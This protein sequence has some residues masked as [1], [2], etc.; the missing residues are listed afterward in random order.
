MV[1]TSIPN[2]HVTS[3]FRQYPGELD[4]AVVPEWL[5]AAS[6][7]ASYARVI[8]L[9]DE[10]GQVES[11]M[12]RFIESGSYWDQNSPQHVTNELGEVN[13]K[14]VWINEM[15]ED[16]H[17]SPHFLRLPTARYWVL[18]MSAAPRDGEYV[19]QR[20]V[21]NKRGVGPV[22]Y[23]IESAISEADV[24]LRILNLAVAAELERVK[25]CDNCFKWFYAE[26]SH[27]RFCPGGQCRLAK[28]SKSPKYKEY[29]RQYMRARRAQEAAE[30]A[31]QFAK[32]KGR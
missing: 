28:Y 11:R 17:F 12:N 6:G 16:Y 26:R 18:L 22:R 19:F 9:L 24:V 8:K 1:T 23:P 14:R 30:Q 27:Q 13:A 15:L 10:M 31:A 4:S 5:N 25:Q 29:R 21:D 32:R 3:G 20:V 2:L 7:T